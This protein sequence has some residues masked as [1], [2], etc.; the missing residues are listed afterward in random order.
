MTRAPWPRSD[1]ARALADV[2][3]AEDEG[4][5]AP[6]EHVRRPV[7]AVDQRVSTAVL[8]VE[9][10]LR[11]RVVHVDRREQEGRVGLHL[12]EAVDAGGRLFRDALDVRSRTGEPRRV[13]GERAGHHLEQRSHLVG[14]VHP[15]RVD[16]AVGLEELALVDHQRGVA[17]VVEDHVRAAFG[18]GE[19]VEE[20]VPVLPERLTLPREDRHATR[21]GFG[22]VTTDDNR[23]GCVVLGREDVARR[24]PDLR[25]EVDEGL[26]EYRGL[27]GHV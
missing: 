26:D 1:S 12:V 4:D 22:S 3:V 19:G 6:D 24:P 21:L 15:G 5:L 18:P 8:V 7:D 9:L 10:R 25:A 17:T 16:A 14:V 27:D 2:A 11:D 20:E 23:G 13:L